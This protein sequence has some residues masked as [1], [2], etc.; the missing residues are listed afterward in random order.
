MPTL[1]IAVTNHKKIKTV[2]SAH[3]GDHVRQTSTEIKFN[4]LLEEYRASIL[5]LL[6]EQFNELDTEEKQSVSRLYN[7]YVASMDWCT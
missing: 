5:P 1:I 2:A 7:F 3:C 6:R 4:S